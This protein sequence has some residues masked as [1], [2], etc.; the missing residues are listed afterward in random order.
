MK[1]VVKVDDSIYYMAISQTVTRKPMFWMY[2]EHLKELNISHCTNID[3]TDFVSCITG[4][5]KL[6]KLVMISSIYVILHKFNVL[7]FLIH[8][9]IPCAGYIVFNKMNSKLHVQFYFVQTSNTKQVYFF[10]FFNSQCNAMYRINCIQFIVL[11]D[12]TFNSMHKV[13]SIQSTEL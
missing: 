12:S 10:V 8:N 6:Q 5:C 2:F 13:N 7:H 9:S 11:L 1:T 4:C 3:S